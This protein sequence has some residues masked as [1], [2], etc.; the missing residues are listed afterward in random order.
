MD[1]APIGEFNPGAQRQITLDE[2]G[3]PIKFPK[4]GYLLTETTTRASV[5]FN[6]ADGI[7]PYVAENVNKDYIEKI[8]HCDFRWK[9]LRPPRVEIKISSMC[10]CTLEQ[11]AKVAACVAKK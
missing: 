3:V 9:D 10:V 4:V 11:L 1:E 7:E 6:G 2:Y 8:E 5:F